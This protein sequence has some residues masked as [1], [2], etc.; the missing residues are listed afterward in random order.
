MFHSNKEYERVIDRI[1]YVIILKSNI[2]IPLKKLFTMQ[3]LVVL[4]IFGFN[5]NHNH[6]YSETFLEKCSYEQYENVILR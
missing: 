3:S 6:Y 2:F 4:I 1:R 5:K